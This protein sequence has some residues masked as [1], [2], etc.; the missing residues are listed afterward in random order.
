MAAVIY[1]VPGIGKTSMAAYAPSPV[2]MTDPA[3][4]GI[5]TL[6]NFHRVPASIPQIQANTWA[7]TLGVIDSLAEGGHNYRTLIMDAIGG[8]EALCHEEVTR[9]DFHGE[10]G[11]KGFASY[12]K[13]Y[14]VALGDW[15]QLLTA[16]DRLRRSGMSVLLIGHSI[17]KPYKNPQGED[18]DRYVPDVHPKT[19]G[20]TEKWADMVLF[21]Q[22]V[23]VV[24]KDGKAQGGQDRIMLTEHHPAY[25]AKNRNGLPGEIE[26]GDS[27]EAAWGNL[28]NA[29]KACAGKDGGG[30]G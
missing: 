23:T 20:I 8:F 3:E 26:M 17:V 25:M 16:L 19:W 29:L 21:L 5:T 14:E 11:D 12:A 1:G 30:N 24:D 7:E 27:G 4:D 10:R 9:R 15:R 28:A 22:Y 18:Y 2:F 13:G 6:K